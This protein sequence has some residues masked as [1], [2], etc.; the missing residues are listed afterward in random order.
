MP[1]AAK[2]I[3]AISF[4]LV[5]FFASSEIIRA[6]PENMSAGKF[7]LVNSAIGFLCGWRVMGKHA[8]RGYQ[9]G[10]ALGIWT[11]TVM[12]FFSLLVHSIY[13]MLSRSTRLDYDGVMDAVKGVFEL[14]SDFAFIMLDSPEAIVIL[15][16]G[17]ILSAWF[18][19]W[20]AYR[21]K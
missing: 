20:A 11:T 4:A 9:A 10:V 12:V 15:V 14:A 2:L 16:V 18:S 8:H 21:W 7:G 5:A 3:A 13:E 6:F 1:T 17:G 19:V